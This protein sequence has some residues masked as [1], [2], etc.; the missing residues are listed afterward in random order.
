MISNL[1]SWFWNKVLCSGWG[2]WM[3]SS[4]FVT[5]MCVKP[6]ETHDFCQ[7]QLEA[8]NS[9]CNLETLLLSALMPNYRLEMKWRGNRRKRSFCNGTC[10]ADVLVPPPDIPFHNRYWLWTG[11]LYL[12]F[13]ERFL[14]THMGPIY[15]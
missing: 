8:I 10:L 15:Y 6:K 4:C 5:F 2:D 13:C 9:I 14:L 7:L 12:P 3:P 1:V 11:R